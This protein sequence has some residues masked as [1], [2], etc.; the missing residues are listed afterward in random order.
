MGMILEILEC[1]TGCHCGA[2]GHTRITVRYSKLY[3]S[4]KCS[5]Q[6]LISFM[7][8]ILFKKEIKLELSF[9]TLKF[10][11]SETMLRVR[12]PVGCEVLTYPTCFVPNWKLK[13]ILEYWRLWL[14]QNM[15][16]TPQVLII[17]LY[18]M[19]CA[20]PLLIFSIETRYNDVIKPGYYPKTHYFQ[21]PFVKSNSNCLC[22]SSIR[23][24]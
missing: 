6:L 19:W 4:Q 20:L 18:T 23:F 22:I 24:W 14:M 12:F 17:W 21:Q 9:C 5:W 1:E 8:L 13:S 2:H 15:Q 7:S 10:T 11:F 3:N 16:L